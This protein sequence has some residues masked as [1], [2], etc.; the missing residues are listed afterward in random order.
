MGRERDEEGD[1]RL[2][3]ARDE[4]WGRSNVVGVGDVHVSMCEWVFLRAA[5]SGVLRVRYGGEE[6][7]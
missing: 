1:E 4:V 5:E 2:E 3:V 7:R 6:G